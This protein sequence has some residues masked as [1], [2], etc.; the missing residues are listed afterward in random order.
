MALGLKCS[1]MVHP[2]FRNYLAASIRPVLEV[3]LKTV[4]ER[5]HGRRQYMAYSAVPVH[6]FA[7][8]KAKAKGKGKSQTRVNISAAFVED[9]INL[10]EVNE[11]MKSVIEAL[12]DNFNKTLNIRTSPVYSCS[13]QGYK[14]KWNESESRS[15]RGTNS[16]THSPSNQRAQRNAGETGQTEHQQGQILFMEGLYQ[17]NE[18]AEEIQGY[19]LGGYH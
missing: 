13:Y 4:H 14:R 11:E 17:C 5:Q 2:A 15:G 16:G 3:T 12:K 9:I 6:H 7:T 19:S 18:Q 1:R 8:K 10:E